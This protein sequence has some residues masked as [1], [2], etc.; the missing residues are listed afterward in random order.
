M[1]ETRYDILQALSEPAAEGSDPVRQMFSDVWSRLAPL[2]REMSH[3]LQGDLPL[4]Y[5][6]F[7]AAGD[8][9]Q[10]L[11]SLG[12]VIGLE[13]SADGLRRMA[14]M[15]VPDDKA[16]P[17]EYNLDVDPALRQLFGLESPEPTKAPEPVG[18]LSWFIKPARASTDSPELRKKLKN[19]V[20]AR[21]E[22]SEYLS[23]VHQLL[24]ETTTRTLD[25]ARLD[26]K[27][28]KLYHDML[29]ATAWQESCWRQFIRTDKG[30]KP[31][32]SSSGSIG[33]MQVNRKVWRGMYDAGKL[34]TDIA[35]NAQAGSEILLHYFRDYALKK[36]LGKSGSVDD[37][38]RAS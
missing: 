29:L 18:I 13:I 32:T 22:I 16:D 36:E 26:A 2:L 7:I 27:Y 3:D 5:L 4:Q 30:V 34:E 37:L 11:D 38:A 25:T 21:N 24:N 17:L 35:Y 10:I 15:L 8:L 33:I 23:L 14:R 1:I 12:P 9:L 20:P 28:R 19:W 6:T 31:I